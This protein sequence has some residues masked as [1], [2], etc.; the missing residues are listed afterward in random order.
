MYGCGMCIVYTETDEILRHKTGVFGRVIPNKWTFFSVASISQFIST[1]KG[2]ANLPESLLIG[3]AVLVKW[4][5]LVIIDHC[6]SPN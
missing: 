3:A 6:F 5:F 1:S 4:V 2:E